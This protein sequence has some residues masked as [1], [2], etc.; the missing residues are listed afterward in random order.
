MSNV[1]KEDAKFSC[2]VVDGKL[3]VLGMGFSFDCVFIQ[4]PEIKYKE[5]EGRICA[6]KKIRA[7][8][9]P[10]TQTMWFDPTHVENVNQISSTDMFVEFLLNF[11]GYFDEE[12]VIMF[13]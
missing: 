6:E 5:L 7:G 1:K 13:E 12:N 3:C 9:S 2:E 10:Q 11:V 8:S 4:I